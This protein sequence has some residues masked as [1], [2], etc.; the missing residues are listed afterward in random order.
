MPAWSRQAQGMLDR[1]LSP[2]HYAF[3]DL[4]FLFELVL[5]FAVLAV[6]LPDWHPHV[7]HIFAPFKK[8]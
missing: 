1:P 7:L 4:A 2:E 3:L 8:L 6:F 5:A